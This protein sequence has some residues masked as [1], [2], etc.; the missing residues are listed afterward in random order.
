ML[1]SRFILSAVAV[2]V[3][4]LSPAQAA[5]MKTPL[6]AA[7][8]AYTLDPRHTTVFWQVNHLGF[9]NFVGSF[10]K[11]EASMNYDPVEPSKSTLKVTIDPA[12]LYT[13]VDGF[14]KELTSGGGWIDASKGPITFNSTK[15][16]K[17][18]ETSGLVEG[19]LTLNGVTKHEVM[20]VVFVGAGKNDFAKANAIGFSGSMII[21]RSDF[22]VDKMVPMVSDTVNILVETEFQQ[23]ISESATQ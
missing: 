14:A 9:S 23:K 1:A 22:G 3:L 4:A 8:G 6:T 16:I 19:D 18:A 15:V 21:K 13:N 5:E 11:V 10:T 17:T 7:P 2:G 20:K 12:S